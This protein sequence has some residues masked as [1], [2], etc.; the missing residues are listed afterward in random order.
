MKIDGGQKNFRWSKSDLDRQS[1]KFLC[2]SYCRLQLFRL[3]G[4]QRKLKLDIEKI[5]KA[6]QQDQA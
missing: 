3:K 6:K 4:A 1:L 2:S 5:E